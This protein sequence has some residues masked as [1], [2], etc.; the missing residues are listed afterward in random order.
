MLRGSRAFFVWPE[1]YLPQPLKA[2]AGRCCWPA[3]RWAASCFRAACAAKLAALALLGLVML[4]PRTMQFL[5]P[6]GTFHNLTVTGYAL[7]IAAAAMVTVR[8]G[9]GLVRNASVLVAALLVTG[10]VV[11]CNWISTVNLLNTQAHFATTTQILARLRALPDQDWDGKTDR[12]GRALR[13]AFG[14]SLQT[15]DRRCQRVHGLRCT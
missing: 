11:Q 5:H 10:Y 6:K 15:S 9:T 1:A 4:S 8:L 13:N 7:V 14:L 12:R 3:P 2:A